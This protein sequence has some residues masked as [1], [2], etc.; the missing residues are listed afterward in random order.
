[1]DAAHFER[2][3]WGARRI[4]Q[5]LAVGGRFV[6][7]HYAPPIVAAITGD[8]VHDVLASILRS[9]TSIARRATSVLADRGFGVRAHHK[10]HLYH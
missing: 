4:E 7:T 6:A 1:M 5:S 2:L 9:R 3:E 8:S 10:V